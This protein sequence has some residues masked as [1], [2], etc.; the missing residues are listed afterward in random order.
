MLCLRRRKTTLV[1]LVNR[2]FAIA[3]SMNNGSIDW[4]RA[5]LARAGARRKQDEVKKEDLSQ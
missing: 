4:A 1:D 5:V 2:S 3:S